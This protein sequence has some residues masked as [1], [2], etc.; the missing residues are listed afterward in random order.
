M[1]ER[2]FRKM[3]LASRGVFVRGCVEAVTMGWSGETDYQ[4]FQR[5]SPPD[6]RWMERKRKLDN[7]R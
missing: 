5:E 7:P 4:Q 3:E 6:C 1:A 2:P